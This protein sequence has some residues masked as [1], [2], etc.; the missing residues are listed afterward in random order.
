MLKICFKA[1]VGF[2]IQL[3][4]SVVM[5]LTVSVAIFGRM[6][7]R[8]GDGF[9]SRY[10]DT[11]FQSQSLHISQNKARCPDNLDTHP[12]ELFSSIFVGTNKNPN[13]NKLSCAI[14]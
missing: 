7:R 6:M 4:H 1:K 13:A 11:F 10:G 9:F 3:F 8:A 14:N 12:S 2:Q 5:N